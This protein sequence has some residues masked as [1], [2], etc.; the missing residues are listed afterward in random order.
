MENRNFEKVKTILVGIFPSFN[1][2]VDEDTE[3]LHSLFQ[4]F[5]YFY[6]K[7]QSTFEKKQLQHLAE[8]IDSAIEIQDDLEN[9]VSTCFLEHLRQINAEKALKPLLTQSA[10]ERLHV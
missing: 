6:G 2:Y 8:F 3:T 10:K 5:I 9:A 1:T 7:H 4:D